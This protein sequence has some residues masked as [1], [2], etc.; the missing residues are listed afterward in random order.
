[1]KEAPFRSIRAVRNI[2][3]DS[4][5]RSR[6]SSKCLEIKEPVLEAPNQGVWESHFV[7]RLYSKQKTDNNNDDYTQKI[8]SIEIKS[9]TLQTLLD[10]I[11]HESWLSEPVS[12]KIE[13]LLT[14]HILSLAEM[15]RASLLTFDQLGLVLAPGEFKVSNIG[16]DDEKTYWI[17]I[18]GKIDWNGSGHGRVHYHEHQSTFFFEGSKLIHKLEYFPFEF[19]PPRVELILVYHDLHEAARNQVCKNLIRKLPA[20]DVQMND[21]DFD[22]LAKTIMNGREINNLIKDCA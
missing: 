12:E 6:N 8:L 7:A 13:P 4:T 1:M 11:F 9:H 3:T 10:S 16:V 2:Y 20:N 5:S 22:K 17:I 14:N 19:A 21:G 15:K 18:L